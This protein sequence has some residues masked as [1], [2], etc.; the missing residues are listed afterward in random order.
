M[1]GKS[2]NTIRDRLS[3]SGSFNASVE[4]KNHTN[5]TPTTIIVPVSGIEEY[6]RNPRVY[7]NPAHDL[8]KESIRARG[9]L[10]QIVITKKPDSSN[11]VLLQGGTT[12]LRCMRELYEETGDPKFSQ[13]LCEIRPWSGEDDLLIGHFIENELRGD[14]NWYE[15]SA[16]ICNLQLLFENRSGKSLPGREF[17]IQAAE[18][19]I[20]VRRTALHL[21]RYT[22]DRLSNHLNLRYQQGIG[23]R[24]IERL[25]RLDTATSAIWLDAGANL[26]KYD[27]LFYTHLAEFDRSG[28][29]PELIDNT[30]IGIGDNIQDINYNK[31][32]AMLRAHVI[33]NMPAP[34]YEE[35]YRPPL[36]STRPQPIPRN[37]EFPTQPIPRQP[38]SEPTELTQPTIISLAKTEAHPSSSFDL[39]SAGRLPGRLGKCRALQKKA[40]KLRGKIHRHADLF[41]QQTGNADCLVKLRFGY[42]FIVFNLPKRHPDH[43]NDL[44]TVRDQAWWL[45]IELSQWQTALDRQPKRLPAA[46]VAENADLQ[47]SF[48]ASADPLTTLHRLAETQ[49]IPPPQFNLTTLFMHMSDQALRN[50]N[51][52]IKYYRELYQLSL[53][54]EIWKHETNYE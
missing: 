50:F 33:E 30:I 2:D 29:L 47:K 38:D 3:A 46:A 54:F 27:E 53:N 10:Q 40:S 41:A 19:G 1:N 16:L 7:K 42:G 28:N 23:D 51:Q 14:L 4:S 5:L 34:V 31:V 43:P 36:K 6:E 11:Y 22:V 25:R 32:Q 18:S 39:S 9:L 24:T 13:V 44:R 35:L 20:K 21:Y 52:L 12:R 15:K 49:S 48:N 37:P 17:E 45:L 8:I 26:E